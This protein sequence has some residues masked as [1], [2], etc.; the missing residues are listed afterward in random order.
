MDIASKTKFNDNKEAMEKI[1]EILNSDLETHRKVFFLLINFFVDG[2][3]SFRINF[4]TMTATRK[5][6]ISS[7]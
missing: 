4:R 3:R 1:C 2:K 5:R 7:S 6:D